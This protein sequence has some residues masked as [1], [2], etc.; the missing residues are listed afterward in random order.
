MFI[1]FEAHT[2]YHVRIYVDG[3]NAITGSRSPQMDKHD[4]IVIPS[5]VTLTGYTYSSKTMVQF[6][7][8]PFGHKSFNATN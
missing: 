1:E 3:I 7:C 4:Y 8:P 2:L 5:Q 6:T